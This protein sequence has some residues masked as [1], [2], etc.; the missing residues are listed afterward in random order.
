[1]TLHYD[2]TSNRWTLDGT[3]CQVKQTRACRLAVRR[4]GLWHYFRFARAGD[5]SWGYECTGST[6]L[7]DHR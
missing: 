1:M 7:L 6:R 5:G 3:R 2:E 4:R